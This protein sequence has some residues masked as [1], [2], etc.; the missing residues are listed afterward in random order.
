MLILPAGMT[1]GVA[2]E[3]IKKDL[4]GKEVVF[5]R[6]IL[7]DH[8]LWRYLWD[9]H[10][11]IAGLN[12]YIYSPE[13]VENGSEIVV[14]L[15]LEQKLYKQPV[16][17][18]IRENI[19]YK[20][21]PTIYP[22]FLQLFFR[23]SQTFLPASLLF[24]KLLLVIVDML[25]CLLL[26]KFLEFLKKPTFQIAI[27]VWNPLVIKEIA[28]TGHVDVVTALFLTL[29]LYAFTKKRSSVGVFY[30]AVA[31]LSKLIPIVVVPIIWKRISIKEKIFGI[32]L[33]ATGFF[34]YRDAG[35]RLF[36]SLGV[37]F[38]EWIFNPGFFELVRWV[39]VS[40]FPAINSSTVAKTVSGLL[41]LMLIGYLSLKPEEKPEALIDK[42][43]LALGGLLFLSSA[44]MPWYMVWILPMVSITAKK[45]WVY[46]SL[47][48]FLS[49]CVYIR[50][51]GVE[52]GWRLA[53]IHGGFLISF[54][55]ENFGNLLK[56][57]SE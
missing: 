9:G 46:Y 1:D 37:Y 7:Y 33:V 11:Q 40:L 31:V 30:L 12:P 48:S 25:L 55:V 45:S 53:V 49:Y 5:D 10:Q 36:Q 14:T 38:Q 17:E 4:F 24:W 42:S 2:Y 57:N 23:A 52:E 19:N 6:F 15:D 18:D 22:P 39:S 41:L 54:L 47:L 50:G 21:L 13:E 16:W 20:E 8:D 27:Y 29:T 43:L 56:L 28:G 26:V 3:S 35:E 34:Y 51:D 32:S 44:I